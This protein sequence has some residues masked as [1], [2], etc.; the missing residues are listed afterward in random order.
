MPRP[1]LFLGRLLRRLVEWRG[2]NL[3]VP[4]R[5]VRQPDPA[6]RDLCI[7]VTL[8]RDGRISRAALAHMRAWHECGFMLVV[9]VVTGDIIGF[10]APASLDFAEGILVRENRGYDFG[11]WAGAINRLWPDLSSATLLVTANDSVFGPVESFPGMIERVR[12]SGADVI[13]L[14]ES[15]EIRRHFQSY[16]VFYK[17]RAV[18]SSAFRRFWARVRTGDREFV[19]DRYELT[20]LSRMEAAGLRCEALFPLSAEA[21]PNPTLSDWRGLLDRGFPFVKVQLLRD[22]PH[23]ADIAG[24]EQT[25]SS[26]GYDPGLVRDL[27]PVTADEKPPAG[28]PV[29]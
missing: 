29:P 18:R 19:I 22:N 8:A 6:G 4:A 1:K 11:A 28:K 13:G 5:W 23:A 17:P 9:V 21:G 27:L 14:T 2:D 24:W 12:A 26:R 10:H 20:L 15:H 7:F 16:V 25:L 3:E